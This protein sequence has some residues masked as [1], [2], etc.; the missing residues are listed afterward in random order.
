MHVHKCMHVFIATHGIHSYVRTY[1]YMHM[2][3]HMQK[4]ITC[5]CEFCALALTGLHARAMTG[6]DFREEGWRWHVIRFVN[7]TFTNYTTSPLAPVLVHVRPS[8]H[9]CCC[10]L[11]CM[12]TCPGAMAGI[13]VGAAAGIG[14]VGAAAYFLSKVLIHALV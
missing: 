1:T 9:L 3:S 2:R 4:C 13:G 6:D 7:T 5:R 8:C 14:I 11:L 12:G 10:C